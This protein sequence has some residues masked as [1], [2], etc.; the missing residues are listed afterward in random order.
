MAVELEMVCVLQLPELA[1]N[2]LR[3]T[4]EPHIARCIAGET[5]HFQ[6]MFQQLSGGLIL[7]T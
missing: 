2:C 4:E 7:L 1:S 5:E 6:L 3:P